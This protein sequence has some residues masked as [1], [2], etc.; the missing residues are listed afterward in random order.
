MPQFYIFEIKL[1]PN[2]EYEH[3]VHWAY[4]PDP[5]TARLKAESVYHAILSAAAVSQTKSHSA[6]LLTGDGVAITSQVYTHVIAT[7]TP[8]SEVEAPANE[9]TETAEAPMNEEDNE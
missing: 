4:D 1:L 7:E 9:E 5:Q 2:G 3:Q 8:A 6:T